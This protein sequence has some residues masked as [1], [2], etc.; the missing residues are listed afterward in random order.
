MEWSD[1]RIFLTAV[2]SGSYTAAAPLLGINRTTIGRRFAELEA[3]LGVILFR[4]TPGGH[5]PTAEGALLLE[6]AARIEAEVEHL[7]RRLGQVPAVASPIRI[8]SSAGLASEFLGELAA[9]QQR[10]PDVAIELLGALDPLAAVSER[11]ADLAIA[12]TRSPPRRLTG[13]EVGLLTQAPYARR[14]GARD[15]MLGWGHEMELALP[16]QWTVANPV[17][18][19][20]PAP[21][22][23]SFNSWPAL[24]QAVLAG[25]GR[26]SLWCFAADAEPTL[27]RLA[28]PDPRW[29][30]S[31]WLLHRAAAP[32]TTAMTELMVFMA[33]A[34]RVRI[35]PFQAE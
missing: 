6:T 33:E 28:P 1:L 5:E 24:K 21:G 34:I 9:F 31:L 20:S 2:R 19:G 16:G 26:A 11:R 3:A 18:P 27:E 12:L 32:P 30:S 35:A 29:S 4:E 15:R 14:D 13:M 22:D 7:L 17:R 25:L 8:A 10:R 23:A